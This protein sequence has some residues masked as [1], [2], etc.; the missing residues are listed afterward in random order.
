[1]GKVAQHQQQ[2]QHLT[3]RDWGGGERRLV[4]GM[5]R[6]VQVGKKKDRS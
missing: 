4:G 2:Q 3:G 1:M 6:G 5:T